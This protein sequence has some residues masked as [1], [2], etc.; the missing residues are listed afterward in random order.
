MAQER[1][2]C[3]RLPF[4]ETLF[5]QTVGRIVQKMGWQYLPLPPEYLYNNFWGYLHSLP[6]IPKQV[7]QS[8]FRIVCD[9]DGV[10]PNNPKYIKE[11]L[12]RLSDPQWT[13]VVAIWTQRSIVSEETWVKLPPKL[14]RITSGPATAR[15]P[16]FTEDDIRLLERQALLVDQGEPGNITVLHKGASISSLLTIF[17][18]CNTETSKLV[19]IMYIGSC[20]LDIPF[21]QRFKK[22][23]APLLPIDTPWLFAHAQCI[24]P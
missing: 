17:R 1:P 14:R 10:W 5:K 3:L 11:G 2:I 8:R 4:S 21:A 18:S 16:F 7:W 20:P 23:L 15:F 12:R 6:N 24:L 9:W 19:T 22:E 13:D